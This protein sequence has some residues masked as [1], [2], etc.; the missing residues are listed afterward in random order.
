MNE[1]TRWTHNA[2]SFAYMQKFV[3]TLKFRAVCIT[4]CI[5]NTK[6][7]AG[8]DNYSNGYNN[9]KKDNKIFTFLDAIGML[10]AISEGSTKHLRKIGIDKA[11]AKRL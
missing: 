2:L 1:R 7:A 9:S 11:S 5:N 10:V 3:K 8:N 4:M 6:R